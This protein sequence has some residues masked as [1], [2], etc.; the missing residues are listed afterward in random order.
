MQVIARLLPAMELWWQL[1]TCLGIRGSEAETRHPSSL[2]AASSVRRTG[3]R[4]S[5]MYVLSC[6]GNGCLH[7]PGALQRAGW[8]VLACGLFRDKDVRLMKRLAAARGGVGL[9]RQRHGDQERA[10]RCA[11]AVPLFC[12]PQWCA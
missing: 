9:R 7:R 4:A 2:Q 6:Q 5:M 3:K 8:R 10:E 11:G 12:A 1:N